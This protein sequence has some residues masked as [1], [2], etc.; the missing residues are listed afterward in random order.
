MLRTELC[1][2]PYAVIHLPTGDSNPLNRRPYPIPYNLTPRVQETIDR[3]LEEG[4][5]MKAPVSSPWNEA[6][7]LAAGIGIR[8]SPAIP[9]PKIETILGLIPLVRFTGIR[10]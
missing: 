3:W 8:E 9:F 7:S 6:I 2:L 4:T 1:T 10:D 5:I